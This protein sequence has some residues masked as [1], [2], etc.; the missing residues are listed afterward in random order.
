MTDPDLS[1]GV[2]R[3]EHTEALFDG[4][5]A[6]EGVNARL[7]TAPLMS[8][9][10]RRMVGG[11][12]DASELGFTYFLRTFDLD[13]PPFLALPIFPNRN[14]RHSAL[15]VNADSGIETPAD[16]ALE[17]A[18]SPLDDRHARAAPVTEVS[19]DLFGGAHQ[20][21]HDLFS[22][23]FNVGAATGGGGGERGDHCSGVVA[24]RG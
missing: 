3:Y 14:F 2:Y 21:R 11:E 23:V 10:F 15:F 7:E 19:A 16:L 13:D 18:V 1:V 8:D 24:H 5:V 9:L 4:R 12:L 6:I 17:G 22:E 20:Q